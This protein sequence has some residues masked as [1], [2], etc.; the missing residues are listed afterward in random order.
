MNNSIHP[1]VEIKTSGD[2]SHTLYNPELDETYHSHHGA[3][4]E[5]KHVFVDKGLR[6]LIE[7]KKQIKILE[8][9]FG[10]GLNALLSLAFAEENPSIK[11]DYHTLEPYPLSWEVAKKLNYCDQVS[12]NAGEEGF[13]R[14]H[15]LESGVTAEMLE[16]LTFTKHLIPLDQ[17][18]SEMNFDL[19]FYDAFAP[20]KQAEMWE[21]RQIEHMLTL[22]ARDGV[23]VTYCSKGQ[24]KRDLKA[25]NFLVQELPGPPGKREMTRAIFDRS[26]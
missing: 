5:S 1:N 9:G 8:V 15:D 20:N 16:N 19:V 23:L 10:T 17:F 13:K 22:M 25:L 11:I 18:S 3:I 14:M 26:I 2:G 24:F 21:L 12:L 4:T 7:Q 6:Y